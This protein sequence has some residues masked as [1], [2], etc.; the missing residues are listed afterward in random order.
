MAI[1]HCRL[2]L[3]G[4]GLWAVTRDHRIRTVVDRCSPTAINTTTG[5]SVAM[6]VEPG[7]AVL[8]VILEHVDLVAHAV[9]RT[10]QKIDLYRFAKS[11]R[12]VNRYGDR[13]VLTLKR[14]TV[15]SVLRGSP[16]PCGFH[17]IVIPVQ[18]RTD[19]ESPGLLAN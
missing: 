12:I 14:R 6:P 11:R 17:R 18:N 5:G 19:P 9:G 16:R 3:S 10:S 8:V 15:V 13:H 7:Q 1:W 4:A 2:L